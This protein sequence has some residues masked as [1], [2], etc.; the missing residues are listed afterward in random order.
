MV[1]DC[2]SKGRL[3]RAD[4]YP[5]LVRALVRVLTLGHRFH[6]MAG[7]QLAQADAGQKVL[8]LI[9]QIAP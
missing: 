4:R 2:F 6:L 9:G 1:G 5:V 7:D 8:D 3:K